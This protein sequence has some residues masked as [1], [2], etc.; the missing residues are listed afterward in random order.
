M[1]APLL[2]RNWDLDRSLFECNV[3]CFEQTLAGDTMRA[4]TLFVA[5]VSLDEEWERNKKDERSHP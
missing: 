4:T 2:A 1:K 5:T 3:I